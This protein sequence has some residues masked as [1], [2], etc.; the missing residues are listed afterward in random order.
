MFSKSEIVTNSK[1]LDF[2]CE[3]I[4]GKAPAVPGALGYPMRCKTIIDPF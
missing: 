2:N 1:P 3:I 4:S